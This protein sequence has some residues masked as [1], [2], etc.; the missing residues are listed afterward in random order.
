MSESG[1]FRGRL[2]GGQ[3]EDLN[4]GLRPVAVTRVWQVSGNQN[5]R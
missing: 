5:S 3:T 1:K 4:F 2:C